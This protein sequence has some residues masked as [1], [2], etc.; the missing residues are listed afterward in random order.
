MRRV[1]IPIVAAVLFVC[2][3]GAAPPDPS[4]FLGHPL[5]QDKSPVEW[6]QVTAYFRAL[7]EGSDRVRVVEYG[8]STEGR[9]MIAAIVSAA[10]NLKRLDH[11]QEIQRRLSDPRVTPRDEA[12][13][14]I[15]EGKAIVLITC[16]VH[17]TEVASTLTAMEFA[18]KLASGATPK[19]RQVLDNVIVIVAPSINPDG[20]DIVANWYK[21]TLGTPFEGTSPPELYQKYIGHDN[22]RDWYIFSQAETRAVVSQ[23]HNVWHPQVVY[24]VHQMGSGAARIF[25]P[26]WM[27]PI[28]PNVDPVIAQQANMLGMGMAADLTAAGRK[29]VAVDAVYDFWTP[30]RH[31][32]SYHG[33]MRILSESAS[34]RLFS[35]LVSKPDDLD[36]TAHGYSPRDRSWNHLEPW[37]GGTWRVRDI[38]DDQLIAMESLCWQAAV[39]RDDLLRNFYGIN[40]RAAERREPYAF[41]LPAL[42]RDP[43]GARKLLETL[44]FGAVEIER[45]DSAISSGNMKW[46]LG[47]YIIRMQ[48]PWSAWAKTLLERQ[49]YPDLRESQG[50]PPKRPYDVTAQTLPLL[51]G[52]NVESADAK[53]EGSLSQSHEFQFAAESRLEPEVLS[54]SDGDT[55]KRVTQAWN[56][57]IGVYR[58]SLTG[59][60]RLAP[61]AGFELVKKPRVGLY[62]SFIPNMDEG[63]TRWIFE[64]FGWS[65]ESVSNQ[66][67]RSG[68]RLTGKYDVIVFADQKASAIANGYLPG[69]MPAEYTGGLGVEGAE[70]LKRFLADGGRLIFLNQSGGYASSQLGI[71]VRDAL[72][73]APTRDVY[74]PGSLLNVQSE[75]RD[76]ALAGVP[77]KFTV[78][79][80]SSP[81]WVPLEGAPAKV[82]LRYAPAGVLA[83]GWL[84]GEKYYAGKPALLEV[85]AGKGRV[86]LFGMRPQYR[87]QSYLTLKLLFNAM[88]Q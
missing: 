85:R 80:E 72:E 86:Y 51:M 77:E 71:K 4:S 25:V 78:W 6:A 47:S 65:Y 42:Q 19:L 26:P 58:R 73:G 1:A 48:Q 75:S 34:A 84:L 3:L 8:R 70:A 43:S 54:A 64:Q 62:R 44:D 33:G 74:C 79:N 9:P 38:M 52:V 82:L 22:N 88:T 29:G 2:F 50:G 68:G 76:L 21:R 13:K 87:A 7:A 49:N 63:W 17:S 67:I 24:D 61:A 27:D 31:Y 53:I 57:G 28:D 16:A 11:F 23:L 41:V 45:A 46:P 69:S 36:S 32:Q 39:R 37:P 30:G 20:V 35:P 12:D 10:G 59:E 15:S 5:G 81:V 14:L 56:C 18:W 40:S 55:W 60:F 66:T 83:S